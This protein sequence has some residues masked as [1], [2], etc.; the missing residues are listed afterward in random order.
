[1]YFYKVICSILALLLSGI[2][3]GESVV[4]TDDYFTT[5]INH[6][7]VADVLS[8]DAG[9]NS[10]TRVWNLNNVILNGKVELVNK[11]T[12]IKYFP[13]ENFSGKELITFSVGNQEKGSVPSQ[14]LVEV[15]NGLEEV[16]TS[17]QIG[18]IGLILFQALVIAVIL[19]LALHR[20]FDSR[21]YFLRFEG[22]GFKFPVSLVVSLLFLLALDFDLVTRLLTAILPLDGQKTSSAWGYA[23]SALIISGGSSTVFRLYRNFGLRIPV[24]VDPS[25]VGSEFGWTRV[26]VRVSRGDAS[27]GS[28]NPLNI[29][30]G[31]CFY[32]TIPVGKSEFPATTVMGRSR[33]EIVQS[34]DTEIE[35]SEESGKRWII[36]RKLPKSRTVAIYFDL[37]NLDSQ[38]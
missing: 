7:L 23:L 37:K 29:F 4:P 10:A 25:D 2:A 5:T 12:K 31:G 27:T 18:K 1:V 14:L 20:I 21:F 24:G 32:G 16:L 19:E 22:R 34:G 17:D 28:E 9:V 26:T 11:N 3:N 6:S 13:N 8:N 35:V 33:G 38:T 15:K 36:S 30:L